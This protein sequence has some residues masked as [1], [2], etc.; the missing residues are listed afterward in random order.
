MVTRDQTKVSVVIPAFNEEKTIEEVVKG[1]LSYVDEVLVVDDGSTDETARRALDAGAKVLKQQN[2]GILKSTERGIREASN[3]IIV[4]MDADGQHDPSEIPRIIEPIL[5]GEADLV[6]GTR[7]EIPHFSEKVLTSLTN[8]RVSVR[9]VCTGF[10][11]I[12]QKTAG[13][14]RLHGACL[15]GTFVLEARRR[16]ARV[17]GIPISV[18]ERKDGERRIQTSHIRQFF[19]VLWDVL[20]G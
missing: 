2:K 14:M 5:R 16:G 15:C 6:M 1:A 20:K 12:R 13:E 9:D 4:T 19:V 7:Q 10:R 17:T 8:I 18:K 11:A 3:D